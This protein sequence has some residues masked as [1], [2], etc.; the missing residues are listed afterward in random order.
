MEQNETDK[1]AYSGKLHF[2]SNCSLMAWLWKST[3]TLKGLYAH[4]TQRTSYVWKNEILLGPA[5]I[6][7]FL[8]RNIPTY[9]TV[10]AVKNGSAG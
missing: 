7:D 1:E 5:A 9:D 6:I 4:C 10:C 8:S 3:F 2:F